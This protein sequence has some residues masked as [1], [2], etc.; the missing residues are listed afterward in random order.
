MKTIATYTCKT[1]WPNLG[2]C[3]PHGYCYFLFE[4]RTCGPRR[5]R[6]AQ[7]TR[8]WWFVIF[9]VFANILNFMKLLAG[10]GKV[11]LVRKI[12]GTDAQKLYAM[13]VL[14]KSAVVRKR[15][16]MEHTLTERSVLQEIRDF[17]FLVTLHYAFQ[18]DAKLHLVMGK[19][20]YYPC[21]EC[22]CLCK[23]PLKD[24]VNGGEMFT[25]LHLRGPFSEEDARFYICEIILALDHLHSVSKIST[26]CNSFEAVLTPS[27]PARHCI[28]RHQV[29]KHFAG[30]RW[31][32]CPN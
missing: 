3:G 26:G 19:L 27:P 30:W 25:H 15:K 2:I 32:C 1:V 29:G 13:K 11:F 4:A 14:N 10:Y 17:P 6:I 28:Q 23:H 7:R 31:P 8:N 12:R 22:R 16:V 20:S 5:F 9:Y 21:W 18:T 24:Y